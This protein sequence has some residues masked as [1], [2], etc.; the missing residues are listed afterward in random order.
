MDTI[1]P[2]DGIPNIMDRRRELINKYKQ[3]KISGGVYK[4]TNADNGRF[5]LE[6]GIDL[7]AIRN[8]FDFSVETNTC[9][10][11]LL[12]RDWSGH[13]AQA[14]SFEVLEELEMK[15]DQNQRQFRDDLKEL[16]EIWREKLG[17]ADEY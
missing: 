4:I 10:Y 16:A 8:R 2:R 14:F 17:T 11:H 3:R 1:P 15:D 13:G 6:S 7:A 12:R 5:L 9:M